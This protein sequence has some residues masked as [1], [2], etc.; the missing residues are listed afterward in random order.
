M[1]AFDLE[2]TYLSLD[3]RGSVTHLPVGRDLWETIDRN[4]AVKGG[5]LVGVYT[6]S[7][8]WPHWEMHRGR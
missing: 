2:T 6:M 3:G 8:D 5:T 7:A 4:E 1:A